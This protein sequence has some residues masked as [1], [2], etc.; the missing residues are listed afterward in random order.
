MC[1]IGSD[2]GRTVSTVQRERHSSQAVSAS[3]Q[4]VDHANA[5]VN[6]FMSTTDVWLDIT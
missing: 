4:R 1:T 3:S 6:V 5:C 2:D